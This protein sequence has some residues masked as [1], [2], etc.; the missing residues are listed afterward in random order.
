MTSVYLQQKLNDGDLLH[1]C[2][3]AAN[4][5]D[6]LSKRK[7]VHRDLAARNCM[8]DEMFYLKIADFGLSHNLE[9][10]DYYKMTDKKKPLPV[11]WMAIESLN[12][13]R[14]TTESDV[15]RY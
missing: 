15:V 2:S 10:Q 11:K 4:G 9:S 7:F 6:Y 14:F 3:Q 13:G 1:L 12:T 5:M 8:V